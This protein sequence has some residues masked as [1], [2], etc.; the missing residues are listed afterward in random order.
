MRKG[1]AYGAL[2]VQFCLCVFTLCGEPEGNRYHALEF[3]VEKSRITPPNSVDLIETT[4]EADET[5]E[6]DEMTAF[7]FMPKEPEEGQSELSE[8]SFVVEIPPDGLMGGDSGSSAKGIVAEAGHFSSGTDFS[9]RSVTWPA[10]LPSNWVLD[11]SY[12]ANHQAEITVT[13]NSEASDAED[14][15]GFELDGAGSIKTLDWSSHQRKQAEEDDDDTDVWDIFDNP[16]GI[17][18]VQ[19]ADN[20]E[21]VMFSLLKVDLDIANGQGGSLIDDAKEE[22]PGA[23]TVANL[24]DTDGDMIVDNGDNNV[25]GEED[26]MQLVIRKPDPDLGDKVKLTLSSG[27][28]LWKNS[29]KSSGEE[30]ATEFNTTDLPK[31]LWVEITKKSGALRDKEIELEYKGCKDTVRATGVWAKK[32]G[33]K[34]QNTDALWGNAGNPMKTTFNNLIGKFGI[35]FAAPSGFFHYTIGFEFTVSPSGIGSEPGVVF[36]I[37][38]QIEFKDWTINA[39]AVNKRKPWKTFPAADTANDDT[40]QADEDNT[41]KNDSIYVIDA[42]GERNNGFHDQVVSRNNFYE[43]TRVRFDGAALSG[44]NDDG[45]RCSSKIAW[46]AFYWVENDGAKYKQRAGK[47]NE[48]KERHGALDPAPTP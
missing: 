17:G 31:T 14:S 10:S 29:T 48:V 6:P 9:F 47:V 38:R 11:D 34:N 13:L 21:R 16:D 1:I 35:N 5:N 43:F 23:F 4:I 45:A 25:S 18:Q 15:T 46:R 7:L 22:S 37:T 42:P 3:V 20:P 32:T 19:A 30:T 40:N 12:G 26:L 44:N 39:G 28:K 8:F 36:D 2:W 33:M 41:P 24:N 27:V